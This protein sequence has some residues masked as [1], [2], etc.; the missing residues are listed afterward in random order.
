MQAGEVLSQQHDHFTPS[1][2]L[3][4]LNFYYLYYYTRG[5]TSVSIILLILLEGYI[6]YYLELEVG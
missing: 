3:A 2:W 6:K 4:S 1:A 5:C